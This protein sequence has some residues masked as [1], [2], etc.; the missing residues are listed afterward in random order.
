MLLMRESGIGEPCP[1]PQ[2]PG[3]AG[4]SDSSGGKSRGQTLFRRQSP[5]DLL[6]VDVEGVMEKLNR[7]RPLHA[8]LD[9]WVIDRFIF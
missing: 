7:G 4:G 2:A 6:S 5:Q 9:I 3:Q 8:G 1:L